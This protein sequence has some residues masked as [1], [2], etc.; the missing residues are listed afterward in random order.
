MG[1]RFWR[2]GKWSQKVP[3]GHAFCNGILKLLSE[4]V[5]I[6]ASIGECSKWLWF[7]FIPASKVTIILSIIHSRVWC[8]CFYVHVSFMPD[9]ETSWSG[10]LLL[11]RGSPIAARGGV[12][13]FV[14]K[15]SPLW[16]VQN[17]NPIS[18]P[19]SP[20]APQ[21]LCVLPSRIRRPPPVFYGTLFVEILY[22]Y[23]L[24]GKYKLSI[25][26]F[27]SPASVSASFSHIYVLQNQHPTICG[28]PL[29]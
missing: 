27:L 16:C 22:T 1:L 8:E 19:K 29:W 7:L 4:S 9:V 21:N 13:L 14:L 12:W 5:F 10:V 28:L 17:G 6:L 2:R 15:N 11:V 3:A 23:A 24:Y 18:R 20:A 25:L 26:L